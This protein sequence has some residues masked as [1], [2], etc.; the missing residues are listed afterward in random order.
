MNDEWWNVPHWKYTPW[1][2]FTFNKPTT[3][4]QYYA[5]AFVGGLIPP[6][7]AY[8]NARDSLAYMDDYMNNR[9][10]DYDYVKYPSKTAGY[11]GV[12]ALGSGVRSVSR[13]VESLYQ[14]NER[15]KKR[16]NSDMRRA[17]YDGRLWEQSYRWH[18]YKP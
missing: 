7:G 4:T 8:H 14:N 5:Q 17:F 6:V 3:R 16:Y 15:R 9:G 18:K 13:N 11:S 1:G 2:Y 12:S 10:F